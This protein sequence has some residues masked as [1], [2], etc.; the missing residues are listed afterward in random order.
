M[1]VQ[2]LVTKRLKREENLWLSSL[3]NTI[4]GSHFEDVIRERL[5]LT[6]TINALLYTLSVANPEA[7][8][9]G[10]KSMGTTLNAVL[11][12]IGFVDKNTLVKV[13]NEKKEIALKAEKKITKLT[14]KVKKAKT[15]KDE[16]V[17]DRVKAEKDKVKAVE[18]KVKAE[19]DKVKAVEDKVKAVE[20][21]VKAVEDNTRLIETIEM[22]HN[23]QLQSAAEMLRSGTP[24]ATV[25]KWT[26]LSED[27]IQKLLVNMDLS[28]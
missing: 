12:E 18:D 7:L 28:Q 15:E 14:Q 20:D 25:L 21:K 13:E 24:A 2:L 3:T 4:T 6:T 19:E 8:K 23:K 17:K 11:A 16:A 9:E 1:P 26:T 5:K 22:F 27:E 10:Y